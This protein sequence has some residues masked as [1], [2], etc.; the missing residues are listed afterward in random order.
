MSE[1]STSQCLV[2]TQCHPIDAWGEMRQLQLIS[3]Y[4]GTFHLMLIENTFLDLY[5]RLRSAD[6]T[7]GAALDFAVY[8]LE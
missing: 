7:F 2:Y 4:D 8:H 6:I 5:L 3:H 1:L